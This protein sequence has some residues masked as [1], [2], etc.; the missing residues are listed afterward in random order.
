MK[1]PT[2]ARAFEVRDGKPKLVTMEGE[3]VSKARR[4]PLLASERKKCTHKRQL[5]NYR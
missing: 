3:Y 2:E 1:R 5:R 4:G